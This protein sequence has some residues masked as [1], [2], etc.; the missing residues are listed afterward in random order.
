MKRFLLILMILSASI[1]ALPAEEALSG[2]FS[3]ADRIVSELPVSEEGT[4]LLGGITKDGIFVQLGD[5]FADLTA[6]RLTGGNFPF[7]VVKQYASR[8]YNYSVA[9]W[10]LSG[11]LYGAG[12]GYILTMSLTG[13]DG[14]QLKG[15]E[16]MLKAEQ[17]EGLLIPSRMAAAAAGGSWDLYEPNDTRSSA[18]AIELPFSEPSLNLTSGDEDWFSFEIPEGENSFYLLTA[19]TTGDTDTYMELYGPGDTSSYA[20]DDD[21]GS[22]GNARIQTTLGSSGTWHVLVRGYSSGTSGD[23]GLHISLESQTLGPGEPDEGPE[24][25]NLLELGEAPMEKRI[26]YPSDID[27]FR[28]EL[29]E[30]LTPDQALRI[31]T[32]GGTDTV[33]RL[34]DQYEEFVAGDDDSGQG[35]N[36]MIV[37]SGISAG[38]YFAIVS[39]YEGETGDYQMM[40]DI[41]TPERDE[42][43]DDDT[44]ETA[45][46]IE[47]D[48]EP[49]VR[50]FSPV[51]DV[52]WVKFQVERDGNYRM[53]TMGD[54]DTYM[55]L[56]DGDGYLIEENDDAD[57]Y[58]A[59]IV[60]RLRPGTYYMKVYPYG[61]ASIF[62]NYRLVVE[63]QR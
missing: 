52:D 38:T 41:V 30:S 45:S 37:A 40:A 48:G 39:S 16:F 20:E 21:G 46:I 35:K 50:S 61:T 8:G 1:T 28:I 56:Y 13:S 33:M 62:D 23:Y 7:S 6:N 59:A 55:E 49:Q 57:D 42:Y 19:Y 51:G 32:T 5:L 63:T 47:I 12:S 43:E 44:M 36:A 24:L 60:R 2:L 29:E 15:W 26:D 58:N 3:A 34:V 54:I 17:I 53:R 18:A 25:A 9:D 27:W 14:M 4:F 11:A 22:G 31:Q 10:T